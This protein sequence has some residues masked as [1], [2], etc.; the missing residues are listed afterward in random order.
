MQ[1]T[2]QLFSDLSYRGQRIGSLQDYD[3]YYSNPSAQAS[4]LHCM[5]NPY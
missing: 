1:C 3:P 4:I 5:A 2:T